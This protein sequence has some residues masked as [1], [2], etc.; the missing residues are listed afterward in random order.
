MDQEQIDPIKQH[1]E[2]VAIKGSLG[3]CRLRPCLEIKVFYEGLFE[4]NTEGI[5][6][7]YNTILPHIKDSITL[8]DI[9]GRMKPKKI[10]KD[11]FDMLPFWVS[12]LDKDRLNYGLILESGKWKTDLSDRAFY[13][14]QVGTVMPGF[15]R[16]ILPLET[17]SDTSDA[18]LQL[19]ID[20]C[21]K[22]RLIAGYAGYGVSMY[23]YPNFEKDGPLYAL[24]NRYYGIDF[25]DPYDFNEYQLSGITSV[26]W[27]TFLGHGHI[28]TLGGKKALKEKLGE[29]ITV[30]ELD[31]G[32]LIQA[33]P[34]P[35]FGDVNRQE[36]LPLYH[37]VGRVLKPIRLP[38]RVLAIYNAIGGNENT[39]KWLARFDD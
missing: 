16:L 14:Y 19:A 10:K 25:T 4:D 1:F 12:E 30:H 34:A 21:E 28:N 22:L 5:L 20:A 2:K 35:G 15:L 23:D 24:S 8:Y 17:I 11:V 13:F 37:H 32:I 36:F 31:H 7:F 27:L 33:G 18:F 26:N 38:E 9:N 29:E 39:K 3:Q 6:H